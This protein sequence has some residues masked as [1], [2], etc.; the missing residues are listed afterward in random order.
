MSSP[1]VL[2]ITHRLA[3]LFAPAA[4]GGSGSATAPPAAAPAV[5]HI[6]PLVVG[7]LLVAVGIIYAIII[8]AAV[9]IICWP[10]RL[11]WPE[12]PRPDAR[13][14][15]ASMRPAEGHRPLGA[16]RAP[17]THAP[18]RATPSESGAP[19]P[20]VAPS[21]VYPHITARWGQKRGQQHE[22]V[23]GSASHDDAGWP[24]VERE[25]EGVGT[26]QWDGKTVRAFAGRPDVLQR[27]AFQ[28]WR[29]QEGRCSEFAARDDRPHAPGTEKRASANGQDATQRNDKGW[30][31]STRQRPGS[32]PAKPP[33]RRPAHVAQPTGGS[34]AG[35]RGN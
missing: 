28:R 34:G 4:L 29:Y 26:V 21:R 31:S 18:N 15:S 22:T 12:G 14:P 27:L 11:K 9:C 8:L 16:H 35:D 33:T 30:S 25:V 1:L 3:S 17:G 5:A 2:H 19:G 6:D 32:P 23:A 20:V 13:E 10:R 7:A 24:V